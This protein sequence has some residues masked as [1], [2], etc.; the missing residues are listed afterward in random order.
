MTIKDKD[1][2]ITSADYTS[3]KD[4]LKLLFKSDSQ[5]AAA[6]DTAPKGR[7]RKQ[8]ADAITAYL[9]SLPKK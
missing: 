5:I 8:I 7:T 2:Q 1:A 6:I 3:L 9:K 4:F